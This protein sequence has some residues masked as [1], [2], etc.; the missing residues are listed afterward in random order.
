VNIE[1]TLVA[2][3]ELGRTGERRALDQEVR[4]I[5]IG[6]GQGVRKDDAAF[7]VGVDD[8]DVEPLARLD[9]VSGPVVL[10]SRSR[11]PE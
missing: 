4:H 6:L 8:L 2:E 5:A 3:R 1:P 10:R 9:N 11:R 7:G